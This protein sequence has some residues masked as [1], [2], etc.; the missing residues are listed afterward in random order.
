MALN[1]RFDGLPLKSAI[2]KIKTGIAD[3]KYQILEDCGKR[4]VGLARLYFDT[5]SAGGTAVDG[6]KWLDAKPSTLAK[7][8]ALA[9][10]GKL[11][12][13]VAMMGVLTGGLKAS[14][15]YQTAG[16]FLRV[17]YTDPTQNYF[18][19]ARPLLPS[20]LPPTWRAACDE[21]MKQDLSAVET[22]NR[23]FSTVRSRIDRN[24]LFQRK[25][26]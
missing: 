12:G 10:R 11:R 25:G 7:R 6:R 3:A 20:K 9:K 14:L 2:A 19:H 8:A 5:L 22:N 21:I 17:S 4:L 23:S 24:K 26:A 18:T 13:P 16:R 1:F 15:G